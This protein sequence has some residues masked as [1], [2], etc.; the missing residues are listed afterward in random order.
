MAHTPKDDFVQY[1]FLTTIRIS[2]VHLL[3][4][5]SIHLPGAAYEDSH[6]A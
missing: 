1:M 2:I 5:S 6:S 4:Q 3:L